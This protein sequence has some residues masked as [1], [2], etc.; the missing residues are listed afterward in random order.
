M[1]SDEKKL[2]VPINDE[3]I[4]KSVKEQY[5]KI[6]N[7]SSGGCC[8]P[9]IPCCG[10]AD[11]VAT[12]IG[13]GRDDLDAVPEDANLG[14]G[15]GAPIAHL[16][17]QPGE[18]VLDL[19][20]GAGFDA[21]LAAPR[22][23]VSGK[24][25]GVDMTPEMIAAAQANA[26]KAGHAHVEFRQGRLEEL[27]VEAN[28]VD[29]VTSNCVINL[30]PDKSKVFA[31]VARVLRPGG[32]MVI[33]DIVLDGVLPESIRQDL[34]S[35]VGCLAGAMLREDYFAAIESAGLGDIEVMKDVDYLGALGKAT[36]EELAA[37]VERTGAT[38]DEL[39]G[40]VHS[41]TLR[42]VKK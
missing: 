27:P 9:A 39:R 16:Q 29:A 2:T 7:K 28:S 14:L 13:Y 6:A 22:V 40:K 18:T 25:I 33:S 37:F 30:V 19:G 31:E 41:V 24:V 36:P 1:S 17:L 11:K 8:A 42:A 21:F 38:M 15:C 23:G 26:A 4:V 32:R 10:D 20:S 12:Q 35:Y 3:K 34:L 5:A